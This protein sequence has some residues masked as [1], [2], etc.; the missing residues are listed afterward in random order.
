MTSSLLVQPGPHP[1]RHPGCRRSAGPGAWHA[2]FVL[3]VGKGGAAPRRPLAGDHLRP[4]RLWRVRQICG[5]GR[6]PAR[7]GPCAGRVAPASRRH[8]PA[9]GRP[10]FRRRHRARRA[11]GRGC[12]GRQPHRDRRRHAQSLGHAVFA[13]GARQCRGVPGAARLRA[14]GDA[15][16]SFALGRQP[17]AGRCDIA[18]IARA[19][20]RRHRPGR[21]LPAGRAIRPR[22]H[23]ASGDGLSA[24]QGADPDPVGRRRPLDRAGDR[25]AP[26]SAHSRARASPTCPMPAT[27]RCSIRR[28]WWRRRLGSSSV[29]C[30]PTR[31]V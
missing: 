7:A 25:A 31:Q 30:R 3:R 18:G 29:S 1:L 28:T 13:A 23:Q 22:F 2:E 12:A 16:G 21:L 9:S 26:A 14:R 20:D 11:S 15:G 5:A 24:H 4:R 8:P 6:P 17:R 27:S 19:V 10:R